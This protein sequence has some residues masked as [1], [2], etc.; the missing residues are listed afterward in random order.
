MSRTFR[1][2]HYL[3]EH[4]SSWYR[5]YRRVL[6]DYVKSDFKYHID[7]TQRVESVVDDLHACYFRRVW[8]YEYRVATKTEIRKINKERYGESSHRNCRSPGKEYRSFR[9]RQ[10]RQ[11][12]NRELHHFMNNPDY[13]PMNYEEPIS[14]HWDWR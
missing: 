6:G 11:R 9:H 4:G 7:Y 13:E 8:Y 1:C 12:D 3:E 14:C 2:K 5:K 10:N